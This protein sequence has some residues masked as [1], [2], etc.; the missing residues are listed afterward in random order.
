MGTM[1]F[2]GEATLILKGRDGDREYRYLI[3][4][5]WDGDYENYTMEI[6]LLGIV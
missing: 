6:I 3:L 2:M 4:K 5:G 1:T